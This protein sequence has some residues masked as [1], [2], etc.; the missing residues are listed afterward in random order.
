MRLCAT[1]LQRS[2]KTLRQ[3]W[4]RVTGK[5]TTCIC[6]LN[7]RRKWRFPIWLTASRAFPR[8]VSGN[9]IQTLLCGTTRAFSGLRVTLLPHVEA[10]RCPAFVSTLKSNGK[11]CECFALNL[12]YPRPQRRGFTRYSIMTTM[13]MQGLNVGRI[14]TQAI[15]GDDE[16]EMGV[17]LPELGNEAFGG[18]AL[19]IIFLRTIL[20]DNRFGHQRNHFT[21][22]RMDKRCTQHLMIIGDRPVAMDFLQTRR[23]VNRRGGKIPRTIEGH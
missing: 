21:E 16:L 10:H 19:T 2:A 11:T 23:T 14:R 20:F 6:W 3:S 22:I 8:V 15:F 18:I 7:T 9:S 5:M 4:L 12:L 1:S 17:V 13:I